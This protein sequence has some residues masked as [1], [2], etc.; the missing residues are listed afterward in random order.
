[1]QTCAYFQKLLF[2][3]STQAILWYFT[4]W[5]CKVMSHDLENFKSKN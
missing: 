4:R 3:R 5:M 2:F 1:M